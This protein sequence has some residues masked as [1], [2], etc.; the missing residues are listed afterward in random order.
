[1]KQVFLKRGTA[2]VRDVPS[3]SIDDDEVLVRV[4]A[5]CVSIGTESA[6][7]KATGAPLWQRVLQRPAN[8]LKVAQKITE[9]GPMLAWKMVQDKKSEE[10]PMGY[11][12]AGVVEE[13]GKD[14]WD[15]VPGDRV[16]CAGGGYAYHAE[17]VRVPRNLCVRVPQSVSWKAASTVALG[18]IALQGVR[19]SDPTMGETMVVLGLGSLGQLVTQLL[20]SNGCRVIGVDPDKTRVR[21]AE[22]F[23]MDLGLSTDSGSLD[24]KVAQL[25][26]GIGADCV[27]VTAASNS[28]EL[29]STAFRMCRRRGRVV[30]IG[31]VGLDLKRD[32]FYAKEIDFFISTSYGPGRY[33]QRYEELG[34][35]Y[36]ISYVRWTE[37]RNMGEYIRQLEQG[38]VRID[39]LISSEYD[40][41]EVG[42]L[43]SEMLDQTTRPLFLVLAYKE[44]SVPE[45]RLQ[46]PGIV[47][48]DSAGAGDRIR[49]GLIGVGTFAKGYHL[50][51]LRKLSGRFELHAIASRT[52]S[53]SMQL[54][55]SSGASYVTTRSEDI[56][57][58]SD[59][60]AVIVATRHDLHAQLTLAA[61]K[62]GKHVFVE[63]PLTINDREIDALEQYYSDSSLLNKPI[64]LTGYNRRFSP[65]GISLKA[66][67]ACRS[68]PLMI[69]YRMN[70]GFIPK[71]H[72]TQGR[73]GGGRNI[74][75]ACHIYD[76]FQFI[77]G[78]TVV[79]VSAES[80]APK[81][82][83]FI[84]TDNFVAT[85]KFEDGSVATL[86]YS[87][88]GNSAYPKE[89]AELFVDQ[90]L[91]YLN[92]YRDLRVYGAPQHNTKTPNQ[93]KGHLEIL[94]AF[95]DA[96]RSGKPAIPIADQ[97][98]T[99]RVTTAIQRLL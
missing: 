41:N 44:K 7:V 16:A 14:V 54:A 21:A 86:T 37:N 94:S 35:D 40:V 3:P 24:E 8:V 96:I 47:R 52:G 63:K 46:A 19:R 49:V 89:T 45:K 26:D 15:F 10:T 53:R 13:T 82:G 85:L 43:Y 87:A 65:H 75:E 55:E 78:C 28:S 90:K 42:K 31:D 72:W 79:S 60:D 93:Q 30:L 25:T 29:I 34:L 20:H 83:P 77:T 6:S 48:R 68:G 58:D 67:A 27:I 51:N 9:D 38:R 80:I 61:L 71:D 1:M 76:F 17:F 22:N 95:A 23:G 56:L 62:A 66:V 74:G 73:E 91:A 64:L 36:P 92:D 5:S 50:P 18:A 97:I 70:A 57:E 84:R 4:C 2:I 98:A 39:E 33:D 59:I 81:A 32:D 88:M 12:I 99:A 11:S 69:S